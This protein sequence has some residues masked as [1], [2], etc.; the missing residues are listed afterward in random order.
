[1]SLPCSS[2]SLTLSLSPRQRH[3]PGH[4]L[5]PSSVSVWPRATLPARSLPAPPLSPLSLSWSLPYPS[6]L[7]SASHLL[8]TSSAVVRPRAASPARAPPVPSLSRMSLF[9]L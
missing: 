1:M 5:Q 8:Q 9:L 3:Q 7:A 6:Q 2:V 4:L